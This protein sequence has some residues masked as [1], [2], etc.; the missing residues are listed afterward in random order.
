ME[1]LGE[2]SAQP[3]YNIA[4]TCIFMIISI[5][6]YQQYKCTHLEDGYAGNISKREKNEAKTFRNKNC[7]FGSVGSLNVDKKKSYDK[8]L[9]KHN[10]LA[11]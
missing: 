3:V 2:S 8:S 11:T 9:L 7:G 1:I 10:H 4:I 5:N 6:M